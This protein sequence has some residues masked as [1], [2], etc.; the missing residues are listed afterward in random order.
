[1]AMALDEAKAARNAA[2]EAFRLQLAQVQEDLS[3]RGIGGRIADRAG[4][5]IADAADVAGEHKGVVAGTI[6]AL[7]LWLLRGPI[8]HLLSRLWDDDGEETE[9]NADDD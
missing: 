5:A 4:E 3:A 7:A 2:H 8:I 9:R 1:M 6:A